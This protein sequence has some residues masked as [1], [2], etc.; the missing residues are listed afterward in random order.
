MSIGN[1]DVLNTRTKFERQIYIFCQLKSSSFE[2]VITTTS[3]IENT[4]NVMMSQ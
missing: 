1:A 2:K 4:L 3:K